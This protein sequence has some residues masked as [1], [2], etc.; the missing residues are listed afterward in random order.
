MWIGPRLSCLIAEQKVTLQEVAAELKSVL[1]MYGVDSLQAIA[2][3]V[4]ILRVV[5]GVRE[6]RQLVLFTSNLRF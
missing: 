2:P 1:T 4:S 3:V 5:G 6:L